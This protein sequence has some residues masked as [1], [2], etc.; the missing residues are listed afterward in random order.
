M[1]FV[2]ALSQRQAWLEMNP[3]LGRDGDSLPCSRVATDPRR[4][5][6]SR[7]RSETANLYSPACRQCAFEGGQDT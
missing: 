6:V 5:N 7:E 4:L 2:D 1:V 3:F